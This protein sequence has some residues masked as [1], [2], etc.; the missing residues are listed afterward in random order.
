MCFEMPWSW[1]AIVENLRRQWDEDDSHI[2]HNM[3]TEYERSLNSEPWFF[4]GRDQ[5][6]HGLLFEDFKI[7]IQKIKNTKS[8]YKLKND[9]I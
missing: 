7:G 8:H 5:Y 1:F 9:S 4:E 2:L 6:K 3:I